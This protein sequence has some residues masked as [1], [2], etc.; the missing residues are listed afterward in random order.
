MTF[1]LAHSATSYAR[2]GRGWL[3][4]AALI[5]AAS[6]AVAASTPASNTTNVRGQRYCE[7]LLGFVQKKNA[8]I[9]VYNTYGLNDCPS[10]AWKAINP[11]QVKSQYGAKFIELNGPRLWM[12]DAFSSNTTTLDPTVKNIGGIEMRQAGLLKMRTKDVRSFI[13]GN[14]PYK[15]G[16]V[17]RNTVWIYQPSKPLF[18]L[19]DPQGRIFVMQALSQQIQPLMPVDLPNLGAK[20]KL[21]AGWTYRPFTP[22][23]TVQV[24]AVG[25]VAQVTQDELRNTYQLS[26]LPAAR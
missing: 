14:S 20:L 25:G 11:A 8:S 4:V 22:R 16:T 5:F 9:K 19:I 18:E 15:V 17:N 7:V 6:G 26:Q 21:P 10:A 3:T 2:S 23:T 13:S 24:A 1:A 12:M